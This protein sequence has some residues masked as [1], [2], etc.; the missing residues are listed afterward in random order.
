MAINL[1][2]VFSFL[3]FS[4]VFSQTD[5]GG[6]INSYEAV[7]SITNPG[8]TT[9][10]T[11]PG[12]LN[13]IDVADASAFSVGDKALIVQL[14][15]ATI[16]QS[17]TATGGTITDLGNAGNYEFFD[18]SSI[19]GNS[20]FP[21]APL[22]NTYDS[23][24][25]VQIVR[26]PNYSGDVNIVSELQALPWDDVAGEGGII[27]LFVEGTLTFNANINASGSGYI[28]V[29]MS[30]NGLPDDCS[31]A[32]NTQYNMPTGNTDGWFKGGGVAVAGVNNVKGRSPLGN[33]GGSG[34]SGDT[35]GGGGANYGSGGIGGNRWCDFGTVAGGIGGN[36]LSTFIANQNRVFFGGAGGAGFVT[37]NNPSQA[38]NGGGIV[39]LRAETIVGNGFTI[40]ASGTNALAVNPVGAPDGGG[41]GGAG[42]SVAFDV[43]SY[44]GTIN[45]DISGGDGQTLNTDIVHGPG[46]G[47]GGGVFLHNL[48][49]VPAGITI[50][51][52][53]GT[54]GTH[55]GAQ[56]GNSNGA[57]D[58]SPGGIISYYNFVE[59][60][61]TDNT[62]GTNDG[63]PDICDLDSDNDGI[64]DSV[65]DGG[66]G[67][68]PSLD[69]DGDGIP[70]YIDQ[71]DPGVP[72]FVDANG[73]GVNDVYDTD[74]DGTPDF[75]DLD[76]DNDGCFDSIESG[77]TDSNNDGFLDGDGFNAFGQVTTG[78]AIT[79]G[80]DGY[81]GNETI[82]TE[83]NYNALTN[84]T[85][86]ANDVITFTVENQSITSTTV[87]TGTAPNTLPDYNDPSATTGTSG[88]MY[89]WYLGDPTTTGV[90]LS[91]DATYSGVNSASLNVVTDSSLDGNQYCVV[92]TNTSSLCE[93]ITCATLTVLDPCDAL[94][95]GN[96][97]T[98]G[99]GVSDYCD[100]DDDNDGILDINDV[101]CSS[102]PLA[103][104]QT[105]SDNTGSN[106]NPE[107]IPNV[108]AYGGASVTFGYELYGGS[109][110]NLSGV[111]SQNNPVILPD[112]DYI[113]TIADG[114]TYPDN[115][116]VR[117]YFTFSEPVYNVNFKLGGLDDYDRAD[118]FATNGSDNLPVNIS[119]VNIGANLT[120]NGQSA[121]TGASANAN[122][123]ANSIAI[124]VEGPVT[125]IVITV[126]KQDGDEAANVELQ[127]YEMQYC[128]AI[129]TDGDGVNDIVDLDSDNDGIY[130]VDEV[131]GVDANN[132]GMADGVVDP[133]TG[134]PSTAGTGITPID[135]LNDGSFD[136]QNTDSDGDGC[137]D[138]NEAYGNVTAAGSDNGQFGEPDPANVDAD[139]LV[140]EGEINY[141]IGTNAAV[142]NPLLSPACNPC[143][144]TISGNDDNDGDN[145]SDI[146][147]IDDDNDGILDIYELDCSSGPVALGQTFADATGSNFNPEYI[148]NLF[149]YNGASV[150]FGY[151]LRGG[152]AWNG[153][154]SSQNNGA[155]AP[156]GEYINTIPD[157]TNFPNGE[158]VNYY[159]T[160]TQPVYNVNFKVG[161]IDDFDRAD[162]VAT[163]GAQNIPV[164]ISDINVGANLTINGQSAV[165]G[166]SANAN[167]PFNSIQIE[168]Q[169]PVTEIIVTVGKQNGSTG[170]VELQFYEFEYCLGI[171]TDG[172]G[173]DDI[174]DLDSD[175]DG[176]YDVDE[177]GN[178][179]LDTN[180]DGILDSNDT[181][182]NDGDGNG[183]D[184]TAEATA[185]IDTLSDGSYDFQNTD[186]DGDGCPDANEAYDNPF[187]SGS[188]G[189]QFGEPDPAS[190]DSNNGLVTETGVDYS[191]GTNAAVTDSGIATSCVINPSITT[192][193]TFT[194]IDGNA[195]TTEYSAVG[196]VINY[197]ITLTNSGNVDVYSPTMVDTT[198][199]AAPVRGADAPG[200]N[201][202]V[203]DVGETWTYT[204][205]YTV[206]QADLDNGS[207]TNTAE[208]DGSADTTNDG[209][210]DTPV[211]NDES[212]TVNGIE[213]PSLEA[214][215]V[216]AISNDVLPAGASLGDELTYTITVENTGNV[217]LT[218]VAL[219]DTFV[220][221]NGNP[222]TLTGPTFV[223]SDLGSLEGTL[224]VGETATY[225]ATYV[226][227]QSDVDAGGVSNSVVAD[228]DSPAGTTVSDTSDDG[229]DLDGNTSDDPTETTISQDPMLAIE[230]TSSLDL[231]ADGIATVGDIIT[232]TYI[233]TNTGNVTLFDVNVTE[234]A[235]DFTG[236][237][238]LPTPTYVSGGSDEDGE[239][240]LEDMIVGSGTIVYTATYA[241]TQADID[242]GIVTN[243]AIASGTGPL[244]DGITDDSDDPTDLT[245]ND[246]PTDTV[247]PQL[248]IL[249]IDK[250]SSLDLG[251]DGVA[252]VGDI[253]TYTYTVTNTGNVTIFD[254]SVTEDAANFTGTGILPTPTYVSG[255][256]DEDG[257]A[258]LEDM[259]VGSGTI[260]YTAT[261]AL[262]QADIDAGI[263]TN[264]AIAVGTDPLDGGVSDDS[265][266]PTDPTSNDDPTDTAVPQLP[267]MDIEKI[268]SLDTGADGVADVGDI[269]T[270]TYTVTNTGNVTLFDINVTEDAAD[271]TGTGVLPTPTYVSG[272]SDEDGEADLED[273]IVGSGTIV[274]TAT[275]ALTQA[276]IDAGIV[277]NQAV[278]NG[279]DPLGGSV[280]DDSD[281]GDD[282]DGNTEDDVTNTEIIQVPMISLIKTTLPLEDTNGDGIEGSLDDIISYVFIVENTGNVTLTNIEVEDLL[283]GLNLVGGPIAQLLPGE[284]DSTTFTAT[285]QIT[286]IDLDTGFV[287]NSATV[288]AE[289][290]SGD[291]GD[292][293]DD[294]TD[295]SDDPNDTND[296]DN[297]GD[298][299][300]DDPTVTPVNSIFDL[301]VTKVVDEI[302]PVVGDE[303]VFTIE[304][305]NIGNVTATNVVISEQI[306]TG[307]VFV[308][309]IT[310]AGTYS[311]FDGEWTVG[312]LDPDQVEILEIT[313][314]VLGFGDYVNTAFVDSADGG[315]DIDPVND[316][317]TASVDP[318]CLT[319]YNEFSPN[320]DGVNETFIIDCLERFPNNKLEVYN[321]WGNVVYS[322]RGYLNDWSGTTNGRAVMGQSDELPV[323]TYYYVLDLGDGSEPRVG[324]LYINR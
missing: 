17:N 264:Q 126:G 89:Q 221:G 270:Y 294:V 80:Y 216:V 2:I 211:D 147:D 315:V 12:C 7:T 293:T 214:V 190:V 15:G 22:K 82:A 157:G 146:C 158:V 30:V 28:G 62:L 20:I 102:G 105:F 205:S 276:D 66:T 314:E 233:V 170:D 296:T 64:L 120:I 119:D 136:Y 37:T 100:Q 300:P 224:Q 172:D 258:D 185:P 118:F 274:Y 191:I 271:F 323:G 87:Y 45:I 9:C 131:G 74:G 202:G 148:P 197:S 60:I 142:T 33:G 68:D 272:G 215:K 57:A 222:L 77:G 162:F 101:N 143:D 303:I 151:E 227:T 198:A 249:S 306:P 188:D 10:D 52:T 204:V 284:V 6:V 93:N 39:V 73:D 261:Y 85:A 76:S 241:L 103:L 281:D 26:V 319:I 248:P 113:N 251:A 247:I 231:G 41:G 108:Y 302:R 186:S 304:V 133:T 194:D 35:G 130:D 106:F 166:S 34:V 173:V 152:V 316:E 309:A 71:S 97:D 321:R 189:G 277:T 254:V 155:I 40:D 53:G 218:N 156:D 42:G 163:N 268:S 245:S 167:A 92:I 70:N 159:F 107:Y 63:I 263:V 289:G 203:L 234:D 56:S 50:D 252:T 5:I 128:V 279:T 129:D 207:Y 109:A 177:S 310:T 220:D 139:G 292:P 246:D 13:Q 124:Q 320:G 283:P 180:G 232:Y 240:D 65:E 19:V 145:V 25:L 297:N 219:T 141:S 32:P 18:I 165:T 1:A 178:G 94:V 171:D 179:A 256:S 269:I 153:G 44:T 290:P 282:T 122:A 161:G 91:N 78:G 144:A 262:T 110:W 134:I 154:V 199:D 31:I 8:C 125:E 98:D 114:T 117:Y 160:F 16:D 75:Q 90:P 115:D 72:A 27:A 43:K 169:G 183:A 24:G 275:Y 242:A 67:V 184:D 123:P 324:W 206:T 23:V 317:G 47:G 273:M 96:L 104:G 192:V 213:S 11:T 193:K 181:G 267:S 29:Q 36:G 285:Y 174:F 55:T 307:Y 225:T 81:S 38:S 86:I 135:T 278:T 265:D 280:S 230:K 4:Q 164:S 255:G 318:I 288:S 298:G 54:A 223:S 259:I 79:D 266:D 138:A 99:D 209:S 217:T 295:T 132:D 149:P 287:T 14:K 58:G 235:A 111:T 312:Q 3:S 210:G 237:G 59:T 95:S 308:S 212:E 257:E 322:K 239:A 121:V 250:T 61:N 311:E 127:F 200:N 112:G 137:P 187:V 46:G 150:T 168:V 244:G 116:R 175:N 84:Q 48:T 69:E 228:G 196:E 313:V 253:I 243:Q 88:F 286:Q 195:L 140:V 49:T 260:V 51:L 291:L 238:V 226:I 176:I 236:T 208:A 201:D 301:E 299:D 21:T 182:F 83:V 229:D 305:A